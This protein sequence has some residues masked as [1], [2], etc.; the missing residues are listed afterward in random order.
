MTDPPGTT[1]IVSVYEAPHWRIVLT[2]KDK[3]KAL[4]WAREIGDKVRIETITPEAKPS[5]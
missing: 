4:V 1:Y 5:V 2:T 3:G